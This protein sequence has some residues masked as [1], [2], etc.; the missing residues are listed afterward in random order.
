ML[1]VHGSQNEIFAMRYLVH[2][3]NNNNN[4]KNN[5]N[6]WDRT[7]LGRNYSLAFNCSKTCISFLKA[8]GRLVPLWGKQI[9]IIIHWCSFYFYFRCL[10]T[11]ITPCYVP[12]CP[13]RRWRPRPAKGRIVY[14][15]N[16]QQRYLWN[17]QGKPTRSPSGLSECEE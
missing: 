13:A 4:I 2:T 11:V 3:D 5:N 15:H 8:S 7:L 12:T 16:R 10:C 6:R 1:L 17:D 14:C 9:Y